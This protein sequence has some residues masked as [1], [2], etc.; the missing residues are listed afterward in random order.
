MDGKEMEV[1]SKLYTQQSNQSPRNIGNSPT[2]NIRKD[3][4]MSIG[5]MDINQRD[6]R[7]D[8]YEHGHVTKLV[9]LDRDEE[10]TSTDD[11]IALIE[12]GPINEKLRPREPRPDN[13]DIDFCIQ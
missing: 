2:L 7:K 12:D 13:L 9:L 3:L 5:R 8:D 11:P 6:L 1:N 10:R 4:S